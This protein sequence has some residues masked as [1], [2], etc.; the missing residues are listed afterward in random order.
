MPKGSAK[1]NKT[2]NKVKK[3]KIKTKGYGEE[4]EEEEEEALKELAETLD[5]AC[6]NAY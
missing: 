6:L 5:F 4:V 1:Y 2:R 3:V